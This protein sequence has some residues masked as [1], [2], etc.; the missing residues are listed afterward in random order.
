MAVIVSFDRTTSYDDV[1]PPH[2]DRP[3]SSSLV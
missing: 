2:P 1:A 3:S